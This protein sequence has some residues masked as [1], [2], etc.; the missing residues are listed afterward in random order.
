MQ[1]CL[2][3]ARQGRGWI[4]ANGQVQ[5]CVRVVPWLCHAQLRAA[6]TEKRCDYHVLLKPQHEIHLD[7]ACAQVLLITLQDGAPTS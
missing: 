2:S 5:V 1:A 4:Q 7:D 6:Y 3:T